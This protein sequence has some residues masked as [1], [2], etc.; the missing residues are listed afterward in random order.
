MYNE[1]EARLHDLFWAAEGQSEELPLLENFLRQY[2]ETSLELGCGSGRLLLPLMAEGYLI[3]GLDNSEEMLK[4]CREHA[5]ELN[6]LLDPVLHHASIEDFQVGALYGSII[7]PAFT[8]QLVYREK[9]S[10]SLLNIH[11]HLH[12]GGGLY[13]TLFIPWAE[14]TGD[15]EEDSW[16]LDQEA[17]MP[18][19]NLA[20]CHT[21]Y[22]IKRLSQQL[23]RDHRYEIVS[24]EKGIIETSTSTPQLYRYWRREIEMLRHHLVFSVQEIIG[25]FTANAPCDDNS[26]IMTVIATR[27]PD[28]MAPA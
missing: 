1:L 3:E 21:S 23:S 17:A 20:R 2:P 7:I 16:F 10:A 6:P 15:L 18:D 5:G 22:E 12:P 27:D 28:E 14:I 19:G 11:Q 13:L 9:I 8:L 24:Q 25:D 4:L 26:Q